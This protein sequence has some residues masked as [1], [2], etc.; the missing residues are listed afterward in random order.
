MWRL[1]ALMCRLSEV[2][3]ALE[4][5]IVGGDLLNK[6]PNGNSPF[7]T[8]TVTRSKGILRVRN[9]LPMKTEVIRMDNDNPL[10]KIFDQTKDL[11]LQLRE[12]KRMCDAL[13]LSTIIGRCV[14][15]QKSC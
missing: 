5:V 15:N 12:A 11:L 4:D 3:E 10:V 14:T 6:V 2:K 7:C 1:D 8:G 9:A 13:K